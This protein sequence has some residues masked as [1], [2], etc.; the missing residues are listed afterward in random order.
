M[1]S[2]NL[3]WIGYGMQ[4]KNQRRMK[5]KKAKRKKK[6]RKKSKPPMIKFAHKKECFHIKKKKFTTS[7]LFD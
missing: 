6:K 2:A 4:R 7:F 5:M 3:S 1:F